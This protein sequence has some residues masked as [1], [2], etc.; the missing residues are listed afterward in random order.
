MNNISPNNISKVDQPLMILSLAIIVIGFVFVS[1]A[2]WAESYH[3]TES[4]WTFIGKQFIYVI[5]GIP[6]MLVVS[7]SHFKWWQKYTLHIAAVVLILL[8]INAKFGV[9]VGG[10]RR[11][12]NLGII[13]LQVSEF[14][15]LAA[16]LLFTKAFLNRR[17]FIIAAI[18]SGAMMLL[19]L[20]QPDL[21]SCMLIGTGVFFVILAANIN[22]WLI[23]L[24][25]G[26]CAGAVIIHILNTPYQ[27]ARIKYWLDP[28]SDPLGSGYNL[29]QSQYAIGAGQLWGQGLGGS[30]QKLGALPVSHADFIFSIICEEMGFL[31]STAVLLLFFLWILRALQICYSMP[32]NFA[33]M[34]GIGLIGLMAVQIITNIGVATGLL[35]I[36][37]VT[38]PFVSYGGS[39][40]ISSCII[41]GILLNVS[42]FKEWE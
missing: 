8:I 21:G 7:F 13:N 39:S 35:P 18:L 32:D 2:S 5:L 12:L 29:I 37:G 25:V 38:L 24:S 19:T 10:S 36:T 17:G 42:R 40:L 30:L 14:A 15:K 4:A 3:Y 27:L 31:G 20:K 22:L 28:N 6:V 1:S 26:G 9:V 16:I 41:A 34:M 23:G 11:W 33:R